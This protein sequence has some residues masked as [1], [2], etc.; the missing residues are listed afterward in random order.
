MA[1]VSL[2][3]FNGI[4]SAIAFPKVYEKKRNLIRNDQIVGL[5]G[6]VSFKDE[7]DAEILIED[8]VPIED[9]AVLSRSRRGGR[10]DD[11]GYSGRGYDER[12]YAGGP[13]RQ[14][15]S[16]RTQTAETTQKSA[17]NDPVK[18]RVTGS[19]LSQHRDVRSMLYHLTDAMSL[20][21]GE[22]DVLV[23]LPGQKPIRC[24]KES[25]VTFNEE[26]RARL[27]RILGEENV[28]G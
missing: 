2:E 6:R 19:V 12:G 11:S 15:Q 23:Y 17:L 3:D 1:R 27:I 21:P 24:S 5:S 25:R 28:K 7:T 9:I 16:V 18:L 20:F 10:Y 14:N 26:L 4:I 22:R 13:G 8:I